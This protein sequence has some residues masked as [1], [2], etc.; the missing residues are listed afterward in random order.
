[1]ITSSLNC[2]RNAIASLAAC[3]HASGSS[4]F[5]W[6]IGAWMFL[7]VSLGYCV[8]RHCDGSAVKPIWLFTI[9]WIVPPVR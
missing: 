5:T 6:K 8:K 4:A 9:T 3:T 1:M 7:A 2:W